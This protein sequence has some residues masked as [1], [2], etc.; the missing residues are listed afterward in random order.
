MKKENSQGEDRRDWEEAERRPRKK[1]EE[2]GTRTFRATKTLRIT[3]N[4][5]VAKNLRV[6]ENLSVAKSLRV[7][8]I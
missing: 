2:V 5:S 1:T 8:R 3:K 7:V 4:L 6:A